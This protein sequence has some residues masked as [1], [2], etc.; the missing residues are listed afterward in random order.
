MQVGDMVFALL[1]EKNGFKV[2]GLVLAT[3]RSARRHE[4]D[5][6]LEVKVWWAS[7]SNPIGWWREDQLRVISPAS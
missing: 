4:D 3:K 1:D 2:P 5:I 6:Q 7:E